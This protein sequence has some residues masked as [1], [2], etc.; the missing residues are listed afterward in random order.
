MTDLP[1]FPQYHKLALLMSSWHPHSCEVRCGY[2]SVLPNV[3]TQ[4]Q[5]Q[6]I[7]SSMSESEFDGKSVPEYSDEI[8]SE[9]RERISKYIEHTLAPE[10]RK[11]YEAVWD[12]F[13]RFCEER[14]LSPLPAVPQVVAA[15]LTKRAQDL[16]AGTV[17]KDS[18]I[19]SWKHEQEGLRDPTVATN[20]RKVLKGIRQCSDPEKGYG[21]RQPLLTEEIR[22]IVRALPL[23]KPPAES[24]PMR[25][26]EYLRGLRD[27]ALVLLG[28]ASAFRASELIAVRMEHVTFNEAG[29]DIHLPEAK[30]GPRSTG[31]S[32]AMNDD[33]C[34]VQS[35][36]RWTEAAN[37][38]DGTLFRGVGHDAEIAPDSE[39]KPIDYST[40]WR[41]TKKTAE[42]AGIDSDQIGPHS[43]RRGHVTQAKL[44][45]AD[46]DRIRR[47]VGHKNLQSTFEYI[48]D[49]ARMET[50]TSQD[51]GL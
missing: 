35:L 48:G 24:G 16:T 4:H 36:C 31:I 30:T 44:N 26:A 40:L 43:L 15:Y 13:A 19:I 49:V 27:R 32:Y 7:S 37:I 11:S 46:L 51:L 18:R 28:F 25:F 29:V 3:T 41:I 42:A 20:V 12:L 21:Q 45:G 17:S 9:D 23:R 8:S 14:D 6:A 47:H 50:N 2:E 39:A 34:P 1:M 22:D 5:E 38:E 33:F 10:T